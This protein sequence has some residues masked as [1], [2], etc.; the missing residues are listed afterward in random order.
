MCRRRLKGDESPDE[1]PAEPR[2]GSKVQLKQKYYSSLTQRI[3][4]CIDRR[5]IAASWRARRRNAR[6]TL[7]SSPL[8]SDSWLLLPSQKSSKQD[9]TKTKLDKKARNKDK[10]AKN[11]EKAKQ[12]EEFL[13][14][15]P[16][17]PRFKAPELL[18]DHRSFFRCLTRRT[19]S[20]ASVLIL[21]LTQKDTPHSK[22]HGTPPCGKRKRPTRG[23][24]SV[25]RRR[26]VPAPRR[27]R[28]CPN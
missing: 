17:W 11:A 7:L 2:G 22:K 6:S 20:R 10:L 18:M 13:A 27:S 23:R 4:L 26:A 21:S 14:P 9:G 19:T 24:R 25:P 15:S 5:K 1:E 12:L 16:L 8:P 3:Q 28:S